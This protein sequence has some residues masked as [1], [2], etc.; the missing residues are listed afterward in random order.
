[1]VDIKGYEGL[2][3]ITEQ[4]EI[5]SYYLN[6]FKS[7]TDNK[8]YKYVSLFKN[9]K[10][11]FIAVHRLVAQTFIPNPNNLPEVNHIDE[12]KA[13]NNVNNLEW[14][15]QKYNKGYGTARERAAKTQQKFDVNQKAVKCLETGIIYYSTK[16]ASRQTG[17]N[18]TGISKVCNGKRKT[19][20]GYH[21]EFV[22]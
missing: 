11:K 12:N 20:G 2:Y 17:I 13:N 6:D 14:C 10:S 4:G 16:E 5:W 15:T 22:D 21:W 3:A 9:G 19:A 7:Q 1:M 8:G 18:N